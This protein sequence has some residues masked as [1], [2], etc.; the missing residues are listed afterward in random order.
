MQ[1][2]FEKVIFVFEIIASELAFLDSPYKAENTCGR[3][4]MS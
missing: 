3:H 2:Q 4:S 1:K